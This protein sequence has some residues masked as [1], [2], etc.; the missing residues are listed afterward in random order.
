MIANHPTSEIMIKEFSKTCQL[1]TGVNPNRRMRKEHIEFE[2]DSWISVFNV[3]LS[4]ARVVRVYGD[5]WSIPANC[6]NVKELARAIE[7]VTSDILEL[8]EKSGGISSGKLDP[9]VFHW[10]TFGGQ[11]G[12]P[13]SWKVLKFEVGGE[14]GRGVSFHHRSVACLT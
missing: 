8:N 14:T 13:Q 9:M 2:S 1:F 12:T 6:G 3:S 4:L 10:V 5:S 7:I 11:A